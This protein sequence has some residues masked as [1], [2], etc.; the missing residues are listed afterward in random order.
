MN[1]HFFVRVS[2]F[3]LIVLALACFVLVG[4]DGPYFPYA[5]IGA[6]VTICVIVFILSFLHE[7]RR[8]APRLNVYVPK[9]R[10]RKLLITSAIIVSIAVAIILPTVM[11]ASNQ[12]PSQPKLQAH[13]TIVSET[14]GPVMRAHMKLF[15]ERGLIGDTSK[16]K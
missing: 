14:D 15:Q 1:R 6:L 16:K 2:E 12:E 10:Y 13:G 4:S 9:I 7:S 3:F 5:N 8:Y 11:P